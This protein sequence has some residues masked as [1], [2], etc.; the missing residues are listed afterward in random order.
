M[1]SFLTFMPSN[2]HQGNATST[3]SF[4]FLKDDEEPKDDQF[5]V[6]GKYFPRVFF[7]SKCFFLKT[8]V[9]HNLYSKIKV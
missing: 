4:L 8:F 1:D 9:V 7:L 2:Y 5:V 6:D 3:Y